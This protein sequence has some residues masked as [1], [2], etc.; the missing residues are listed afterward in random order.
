M[1]LL[2][3]NYETWARNHSKDHSDRWLRVLYPFHIFRLVDFNLKKVNN[4][5]KFIVDNVSYTIIINEIKTQDNGRYKAT[6]TLSTTVLSEGEQWWHRAWDNVFQIVYSDNFHFITVFSKSEDPT[7][8]LIKK[9]MKGNFTKINQQRSLPVSA[10]L[11]RSLLM[12]ICQDSLPNGRIYSSYN[13]VEQDN[14][15]RELKVPFK[16][17]LDTITPIY[18][19]DRKLWILYSFTEEKA[20]RL[21]IR[22]ADQCDDLYVV[23]CNHTI[24]LHHRATF[25]KVK[26]ISLLEFNNLMVKSPDNNYEKQ[27]KFLQN[28]LTLETHIDPTTLL[29]EIKSP[30]L[31]RYPIIESDLNEALTA[32]KIK[33]GKALDN[34]Y[35][36]ASFNLINSWANTRKKSSNLSIKEKVLLRRMFYF[37]HLIGEFVD[38]LIKVNSPDVKISIISDL[39]IIS[40]YNFQFSFHNMTK[41]KITIEYENSITNSKDEWCGVRLQPVAP[42][43]LKYARVLRQRAISS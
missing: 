15:N 1:Q 24:K 34:L 40:A 38:F 5:Q 42:L 2:N 18:S 19:I 10:I 29:K 7:S 37:K 39:T 43:I 36:L 6:F 4:A 17:H 35:I 26:V 41:S 31:A 8:D 33:P 11:F 13:Y 32:I 28:H 22:I 27:I 23:F 9:F 25:R 30:V 16:K 20:H 21:G 12:Q 14:N 3:L